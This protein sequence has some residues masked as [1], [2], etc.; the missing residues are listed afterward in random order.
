MSGQTEKERINN[1]IHDFCRGKWMRG[2]GCA[3]CVLDKLNVCG[4]G[5]FKCGVPLSRLKEA[6]KIID[7]VMANG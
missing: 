3:V 2:K 4:D 6:E 5:G 7:E 1:K